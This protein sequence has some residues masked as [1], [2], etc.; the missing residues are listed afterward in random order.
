M[1][2][3]SQ[4]LSSKRSASGSTHALLLLCLHIFPHFLLLSQSVVSDSS[5]TPWT[6]TYQVSLS[7]GILQARILE[8][9]ATS[10]S[11]AS[12]QPRDWTC[13]S[14][15]AGGVFTS[16]LPGII[17]DP[18]LSRGYRSSP[19]NRLDCFSPVKT[20]PFL[21]AQKLD[22]GLGSWEASICRDRLQRVFL[23]L[24]PL[25][26]SQLSRSRNPS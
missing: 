9:V 7:M 24:L 23:P 21:A 15:M 2:S 14:C 18:K 16:E 26:A 1:L 12:F 10:F 22:L 11:T 8:W 6:I 13:L 25:S 20:L 5:T 19:A 4:Q 17:A 3:L